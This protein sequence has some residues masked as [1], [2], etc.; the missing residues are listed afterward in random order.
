M[1][2]VYL[3]MSVSHEATLLSLNHES[4]RLRSFGYSL[5]MTT[6]KLGLINKRFSAT[7]TAEVSIYAH[8]PMRAAEI[9]NFFSLKTF[10]SSN[11]EIGLIFRIILV[12]PFG[13]FLTPFIIP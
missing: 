1:N 5:A 7:H 2:K 8:T 10:L 6:T 12:S 9:W 3:P 11:R 13:N 4:K